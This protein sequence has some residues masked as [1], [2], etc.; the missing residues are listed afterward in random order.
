MTV[1][2][3]SAAKAEMHRLLSHGI[4]PEEVARRT[5]MALSRC[6]ALATVLET[7][8]RS[9]TPAAAPPRADMNTDAKDARIAELH[10][11]GLTGKQIAAMT[12]IPHTTVCSRLRIMRKKHLKQQEASPAPPPTTVDSERIDI[13]IR[14]IKS[15]LKDAKDASVSQSQFLYDLAERSRARW[16]SENRGHH[17]VPKEVPR[18][19][20]AISPPS[21][22]S[23]DP[24][25]S[26]SRPAPIGW[27]PASWST[28]SCRTNCTRKSSA[29]RP[30]A[31]PPSER[32]TKAMSET[33]I[34][35]W[36]QRCQQAADE[37]P[38]ADGSG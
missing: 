38:E 28:A 31:P 26:R 4:E 29:A 35:T 33:Q 21:E 23:T 1:Q 17:S 19:R 6:R 16:K 36:M 24:A 8:R 32:E 30:P 25:P 20:S 9:T 15:E 11:E 27:T 12:G 13:E 18:R 37:S 10:G 7:A 14:D 2:E 3:A 5:G 34:K 22:T